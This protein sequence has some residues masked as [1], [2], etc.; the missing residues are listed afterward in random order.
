[1]NK[2]SN[3]VYKNSQT[4]NNAS[5]SS[6]NKAINTITFEAI[7]TNVIPTAN[8]VE[9]SNGVNAT[10]MATI[11][12]NEISGVLGLDTIILPE[13]GSKVLVLQST[14]GNG[15]IK[16]YIVGFLTNNYFYSNINQSLTIGSSKT[17]AF[18]EI[19]GLKRE[20]YKNN[21]PC[22]VAATLPNNLTDGEK[23]FTLKSG[24]GLELRQ[25]LAKLK[26]SELA[27]IETYL[28]DDFVRIVSKNFEHITGF[29]NYKIVNRNNAI[30]VVWEGANYEHETLGLKQLSEKKPFSS[31]SKD[32]IKFEDDDLNNLLYKDGRWR[33]TQY[34]GK[35]GNIFNMY[36]TEPH[37]NLNQED[38]EDNL[39]IPGRLRVHAN[40]DGSFLI[41]SVSDIIIEKVVTIPIPTSTKRVE[42]L[43]ID[44]QKRLDAYQ[45]WQ[46]CNETDNDKWFNIS[47]Q[48]HDYSKWFSNYYS[49]AVF[50]SA[51]YNIP[52]ESSVEDI[53]QF[54]KDLNYEQS[55]TGYQSQYKAQISSFSTI[56]MLKDGSITLYDSYGS[57]IQMCAGDINLSAAKNFN[58]TAGKNI[59]LKAGDDITM[60]AKDSVEITAAFEGILLKSRLWLEQMC[61]R[62]Q[63]L[64]KSLYNPQNGYKDDDGKNT[65]YIER[66]KRNGENNGII[67]STVNSANRG[68]DIIIKANKYYND[69]LNYIN[70]AR[71]VFFNIRDGAGSFV[72]SKVI[73]IKASIM[74]VFSTLKAK[75]VNANIFK[76][77]TELKQN[78]MGVEIKNLTASASDNEISG[79]YKLEDYTDDDEVKNSFSIKA[80]QQCANDVYLQY[81]EPKDYGVTNTEKENRLMFSLTE[82]NIY[83][84]ADRFEGIYEHIK[85][86][87]VVKDLND[88]GTNKT[89]FPYPCNVQMK[90][91]ESKVKTLNEAYGGEIKAEDGANNFKSLNGLDICAYN[92]D[93]KETLKLTE[94]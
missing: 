22:N 36:I 3:I 83:N 6:S 50:K 41:Q 25:N 66:L 63:I 18:G 32:N 77:K 30:S 38:D 79:E 40:I 60:L 75:T 89:R 58:C 11:A 34:M 28:L 61:T 13:I 1:M 87:D 56:K 69:A 43:L 27:S 9:I 42:E 47:Y 44:T 70:R 16:N 55:Q 72:I 53:N 37:S 67:L 84:N 23:T 49:L 94:L 33:F 15:S 91:Y 78:V 29:G 59:N 85:S 93:N 26:G 19:N 10:A 45:T 81:K 17:Q 8:Q 35:L 57:S 76:Q 12:I 88:V 21:S 2:D 65:S 62:G 90:Y 82:Q 7:V 68:S 5:F 74:S 4:V 20:T 14:N 92:K 51:G 80:S 54:S 64:L 86:S 46:P 71:N 52:K 48:L 73:G 31:E 24:V 39:N